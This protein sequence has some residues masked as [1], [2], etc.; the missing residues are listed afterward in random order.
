MRWTA[1][2][3][4]EGVGVEAEVDCQVSKSSA[5]NVSALEEGLCHPF[6][7]ILFMIF[8]SLP[9]FGADLYHRNVRRRCDH[10]SALHA[11]IPVSV[12]F[13]LL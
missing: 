2:S 5:E 6:V 13:L 8:F 10:H 12:F 3:A 4:G 11:C 1:R 9:L 7:F